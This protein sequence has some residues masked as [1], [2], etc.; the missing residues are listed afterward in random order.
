[1]REQVIIKKGFQMKSSPF[2]LFAQVLGLV[3]CRKFAEL[4]RAH[5]A[6]RAAKG[7]GSW[8][9]FVAMAFA[10]LAYANGTRAVIAA[11]TV[12][13]YKRKNNCPHPSCCRW[14]NSI[15]GYFNR[16][17][18]VTVCSHAPPAARSLHASFLHRPQLPVERFPRRLAV[19]AGQ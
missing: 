15:C 13:G 19:Q 2:S 6:E 10:Q 8:E 11:K 12:N 7:F 17:N 3:D 14:D 5:G 1:L 4:A 16:K 18:A 9:Q